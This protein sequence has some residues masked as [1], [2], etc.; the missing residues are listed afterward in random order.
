M[1]PNAPPE[2]SANHD[3]CRIAQDDWEATLLAMKPSDSSLYQIESQWTTQSNQSVPFPH[4]AGRPQLIALAY[5][6]CQYAC[7]RIL[8]D[9]KEIEA[10]IPKGKNIGFT[11][12]SIDP[13]RDTPER[14]EQYASKHG[15]D[16]ER[17][18]LLNGAN[19]DVLELA[20][21][22]G[23]RYVKTATGDYSHSNIITLLNAKG[24]VVHQQ[25]GLG[26]DNAPILS[27]IAEL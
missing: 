2:L 8:A 4:L 16:L 11:I 12:V 5:T 21:L 23:V 24:E 6:N 10:K 13:S 25:N 18:T 15:L 9:L 22:L 1:H 27:R 26:V 14:L 20:N 19:G 7:P 17:W 3:C